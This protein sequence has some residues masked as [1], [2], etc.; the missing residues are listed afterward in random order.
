L[1]PEAINAKMLSDVQALANINNFEGREMKIKKICIAVV[2]LA[3]CISVLWATNKYDPRDA[4]KG[5]QGVRVLVE[6]LT[7]EVE[8]YGLTSQQLQTD[9]E[10]RLRQNGI[11]VLSEGQEQFSAP[12]MPYLYVNVSIMMRKDIPLAVFVILVELK[13]NVFLARDTTKLCIASTWDSKSMVGSVGLDK[14]ETTIRKDV[15]DNV[16]EFI[17]DYLAVNP[18]E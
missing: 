1:I 10:L 13:Q 5:L 15:K 4:L 14:I 9:V 18:K 17:N 3:V 2:A 8:K 7:P 16:D 11:R 12:G 6:K